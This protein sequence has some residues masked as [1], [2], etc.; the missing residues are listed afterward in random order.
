MGQWMAHELGHLATHSAK[1][2]DA[3]KAAKEYR[4]RLKDARQSELKLNK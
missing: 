4:M 3:E 1:E 2:E